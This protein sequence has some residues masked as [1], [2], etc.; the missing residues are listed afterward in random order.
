M[1]KKG[2]RLHVT[3]GEEVNSVRLADISEVNLYGPVSITTPTIAA[4]LRREPR[5]RGIRPVDGSSVRR[6]AL[7]GVRWTP[8]GR[9][10]GSPTT[11]RRR[12]E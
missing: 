5:C 9:S 2:D 8:G 11:R 6:G 10:S 4:L 7:E 1:R 3:V 12:R